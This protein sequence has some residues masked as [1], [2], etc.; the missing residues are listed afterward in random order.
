MKLDKEKTKP[1][2]SISKEIMKIKMGNSEIENRQSTIF[3]TKN[4]FSEQVNK[5]DKLLPRIQEN[6]EDTNHQNQE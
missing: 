4:W 2:V 6:K 5:I 1:K 3:K